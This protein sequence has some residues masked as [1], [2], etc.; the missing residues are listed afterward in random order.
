M[1]R[2]LAGLFAIT[3]LY[4]G[5]QSFWIAGKA[6]LAQVL[7][8]QAWESSLGEDDVIKPWPWADTSPVARLTIPSLHQSFIVMSDAS[9][10]AMAF[11]PGLIAGSLDHA[12]S[13]VIAIGGHRDTHLSQ[14]NELAIGAVVRLQTQA[15]NWRSYRVDRQSI[16]DSRTHTVA[17]NQQR[18][19]LILIT[20]YPFNALQTGGPL[21]YV[22]SA[23]EIAK[24]ANK[25]QG[26]A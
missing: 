15:E 25:T 16:V 6:A 3:A 1:T 2:T 7:L 24:S 12:E 9:G 23:T 18:A 26:H 5:V 21:R 17:I 20:C 13:N 22:V 14:L 4:F 19:G 8:D 10:E 11:G